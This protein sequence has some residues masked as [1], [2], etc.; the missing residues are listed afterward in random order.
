MPGGA[1]RV[2]KYDDTDT[3]APPLQGSPTEMAARIRDYADLGL[4]EVELVVDPITIQS[5]HAL[6]PVLA[7]LDQG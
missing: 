3:E 6:G 4:A 7:E 2:T 1:G 5:I